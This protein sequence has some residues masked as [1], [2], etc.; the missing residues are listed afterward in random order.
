[1]QP[2]E[3]AL[4][5]RTLDLDPRLIYTD[6][7]LQSAWRRRKAELHVAACPDGAVASINAAYVALIAQ[8]EIPRPVEV[9]L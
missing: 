6:H 1:M 9:R 4:M 3:R 5:L 8:A 7:E 2:P